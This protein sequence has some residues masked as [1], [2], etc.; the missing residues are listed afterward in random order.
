MV[1]SGGGSRG[2][3]EAGV[4]SW[5]FENVYP[6]LGEH[7]EFD[8]ISGTSVGAIHSAYVA[9]SNGMPPLE[10]SR[11]LVDTWKE[12]RFDKVLRLSWRDFV[13]IPLRGLGFGQPRERGSGEVAESK[14]GLVDIAPLEEL[15]RTRIPWHRLRANLAAGRPSVLCTA[16]TEVNNGIVRVFLDGPGADTT[17]WRFDP[18][19]D[20]VITLITDL[21]VRASAAIPFLFPAVRIDTCYYVDGGLRLNTPLSPVIRLGA[22]KVLLIGLGNRK[23]KDEKIDYCDAEALTK[24]A[25]LLGKVLDVMLL[26]PI[27]NE[28][29]QLEI[30][31]A[32]LEGGKATF[33]EDFAERLA[34]TLEAVRGVGYQPVDFFM[35]GPSEDIG[36]I[37]AEC[38]RQG[39]E[40]SSVPNMLAALIKRTATMGVPND[41]ADFLS[42]IYFDKVFTERLV[43]LGREDARASHDR[44]MELLAP[45]SGA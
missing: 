25:F 43:E 35:Q 39:G 10:R 34:P 15:T 21:H 7:F 17:P 26:D 20:A 13:G 1:L 6:R 9:S 33:G 23:T 40:G 5:M 2:A 32:L 31:N 18:H 11:M 3:Y 24:P 44:I 30:I 41:E 22:E 14:G 12:M 19:V 36:R 37:A 16:V 28:L 45:P 29:R 4:L 42:Y 38:Y 27:E 8:V